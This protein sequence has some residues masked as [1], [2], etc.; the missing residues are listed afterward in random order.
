[1]FVFV[2][3]SVLIADIVHVR[4][5]N[6]RITI[7]IVIITIITQIQHRHMKCRASIENN[8]KRR[9]EGS[10]TATTASARTFIILIYQ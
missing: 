7:S 3:G 5:A 4:L 6:I 9:I 1:M 8:Q 2:S 10:A